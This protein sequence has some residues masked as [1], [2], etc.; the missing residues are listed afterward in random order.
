M[1]IVCLLSEMGCWGRWVFTQP[2][3][4]DVC[5]GL[6]VS[7]HCVVLLI[8][9]SLHYIMIFWPRYYSVWMWSWELWADTG[10]QRILLCNLEQDL[11]VLQWQSWH[12]LTLPLMHRAFTRGEFWAEQF[13]SK[14]RFDR[15]SRT[16]WIKEKNLLIVWLVSKSANC[17]LFLS[18]FFWFRDP[19]G[20]LH[21]EPEHEDCVCLCCTHHSWMLRVPFLWIRACRLFFSTKN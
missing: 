5:K 18:C 16:V 4:H 20:H 9:T 8:L 19:E 7:V 17:V 10:F 6:W 14:S 12:V 15:T 13:L 1:Y 21:E 3:S 2:L 11:Q